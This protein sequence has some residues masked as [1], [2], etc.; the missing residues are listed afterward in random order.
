MRVTDFTDGT[1]NT[2]LVV[3]AE[4]A[5]PWTKP[6]DIP[7]A[8]TGKLPRL[9]GPFKHVFHAAFADGAVYALSKGVDE[10]A[11]RAFIT[12]AG[13]EVADRDEFTEPVTNTN[14][15]ELRKENQRLEQAVAKAEAELRELRRQR[16]K[17]ALQGDV[18]AETVTVTEALQREQKQLRREL[19]RLRQQVEEEKAGLERLD[20]TKEKPAPRGP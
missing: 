2:L 16:R 10:A 1:S 13:G 19:D 5:V 4:T 17:E 9:G 15:D 18:R 3:E 6:E 7:Y 14:V 11:L 20:K 8:A 12:R